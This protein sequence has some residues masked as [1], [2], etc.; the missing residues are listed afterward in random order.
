MILR[1]LL[2]LRPRL[3]RVPLWLRHARPVRRR[4]CPRSTMSTRTRPSRRARAC[5]SRTSSTRTS[6]P[7]IGP[8]GESWRS[9]RA[10]ATACMNLPTSRSVHAAPRR[11]RDRAR[12]HA[13]EGAAH[14]RPL[15]GEHV[16]ARHRSEARTGSLVRAHRRHAV[17]RRRRPPRSSGPCARECRPSSTTAFTRSS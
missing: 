1:P 9:G 6:M 15:A 4:R 7:I 12:K 3:R 11:P 8:A 17:R 14:A 16:P 5:A 10:P 13:R 2:L